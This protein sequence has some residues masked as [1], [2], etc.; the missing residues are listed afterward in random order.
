MASSPG[1]TPMIG[2]RTS[3]P[4]AF[5]SRVSRFLAVL[6]GMAKPTPAFC[7][8]PPELAGLRIWVL[9]PITCPALFSSGPPL[10]PGLMAASVWMA[11]WVMPC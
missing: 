10:L 8:S 1:V 2:A 5:C 7:P 3:L 4:P 6:I 9:M 11:F